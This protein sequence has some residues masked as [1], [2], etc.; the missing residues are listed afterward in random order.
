MLAPPEVCPKE[1]CLQQRGEHNASPIL[2]QGQISLL[3][4]F[5]QQAQLPILR[6][7]LLIPDLIEEG[8][9]NLG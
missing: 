1:L 8:M 4:K 2:T 9:E 5:T 7:D 6:D 3:G